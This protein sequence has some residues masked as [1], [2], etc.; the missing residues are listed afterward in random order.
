MPEE[1]SAEKRALDLSGEMPSV[2]GVESDEELFLARDLTSSFVKAIKA[3][4]F[5]PPDNP[6]LKGFRE[7]LIK[8]FNFFLNRYEIFT[9]QIGEYDFSFKGKILYENRDIKTS[10]AFLFYKDGL[11]ELRFRKGIEDWEI[12]GLIDVI[13]RSDNINQLEDDLVTLIWERDFTHIGYLATDEFLEDTPIHI[14]ENVEQFR[15]NLVFKPIAHHVEVDILKE[16]AEEGMDLDEILSKAIDEPLPFVLNRGVY[17]LTPE[18]VEGLRKDVENEVDPTFVFNVMDILFEII[19]LEKEVEPF[20]DAVNILIKIL[21]ALI[22]VGDFQKATDLLKRVYITLKTCELKDWQIEMVRRL[23]HEAGEEQRIERIG[24]ILE[25][26]EGI[27][28]EDVNAYLVLLQKNSIKPLIKLLGELKNS[29][30][31]RVVCDS[32]SEIGKNAIEFFTPFLDD[33]RWYLVRNITYILGRIGKEQSL[34]YI[35][36]ALGHEDVRVRREAITAL[37]LIGGMKAIHLLTRALNDGDFRIRAMAALNLGKVGKKAGLIPLL[38]VVQAKDFSKK[39]PVE[40][41]AV[42]DA[43]GMTGSNEAIPIL[44]QLLERKSLFGRGKIDEIRIG[45]ANALA[46][47]GTEEAMAILESGRNS[48]EETIREVCSQALRGR[49]SKETAV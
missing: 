16:E 36:K 30:T 48:K 17:S 37:G 38:E 23:I 10:L 28:L 29:K 35:Q 43:I 45:A 46:M 34:P 47:I 13:K 7:Q 40:I 41:K 19:T 25:K 39:D 8:K 4:R 3:F 21:D 44:R 1:L 27:K 14:P 15:K 11:R 32:L 9:I 33:K 12:D 26:E 49:S 20:Q 5:Y 24:R 2:E 6:T 18:E 42:F 31:R 22:T